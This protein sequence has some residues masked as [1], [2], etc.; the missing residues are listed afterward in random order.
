MLL[1]V[2]F[3]G[4]ARAQHDAHADHALGTVDF[5]VSCS[6]QA[7]VE[8]NH[9]IAESTARGY[10]QQLL[11]VAAGATRKAPLTEARRYSA[12]RN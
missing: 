8:F 11:E 9:A 7:Q 10:Y 2:G 6:A 5:P 12:A 1:L 4:V 3:T